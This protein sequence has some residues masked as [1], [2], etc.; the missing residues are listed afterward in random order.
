[1]LRSDLYRMPEDK[2]ECEI[3]L[4]TTKYSAPADLP[5]RVWVGVFLGVI[6]K[7]KFYL[8]THKETVLSTSESSSRISYEVYECNRNS[9]GK[10]SPHFLH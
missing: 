10:K 1:M 9:P 8:Q 5:V 2:C 6:M 3:S 7:K 4:H